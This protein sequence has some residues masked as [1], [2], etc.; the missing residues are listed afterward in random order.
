MVKIPELRGLLSVGFWGL[1]LLG[2]SFGLVTLIARKCGLAFQL[3]PAQSTVMRANRDSAG[4]QFTEV[5]KESGAAVSI[6]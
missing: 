5:E 1:L 3:Q 6:K 2:V 4:I